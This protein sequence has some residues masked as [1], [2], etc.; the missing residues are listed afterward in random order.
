M[1]VFPITQLTGICSAVLIELNVAVR[2]I[3]I[4]ILLTEN[5]G[6]SGGDFGGGEIRDPAGG[7]FAYR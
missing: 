4:S 2:S 6:V 1:T 5:G 3:V 7:L